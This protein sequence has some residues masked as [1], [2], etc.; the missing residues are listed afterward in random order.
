M[1]VLEENV[2]VKYLDGGT[3]QL[4]VNVSWAVP[5]TGLAGLGVV[6]AL[7]DTSDSSLA[8][9]NCTTPGR[10]PPCFIVREAVSLAM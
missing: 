2:Q 10:Y 4:Q 9:T 7:T 1:D 8:G 3:N 6:V 5:S